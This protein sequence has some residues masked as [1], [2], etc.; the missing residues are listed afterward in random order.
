TNIDV[1]NAIL[2][3]ESKMNEPVFKKLDLEAFHHF[4]K[5][6]YIRELF[7]PAGSI[8]TSKIH[9]TE[10]FALVLSGVVTVVQ[11]DGE[12]LIEA[13]YMQ[14]TK[15]GTKRALYVHEDTVWITIH[16]TSATTVEEVEEEIIAKDF[17]EFEE[18]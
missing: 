2:N 3:L 6:V 9:K 1:R 12:R 18:S 15:P 4:A 7:M 10:H 13:P 17:S 16:P 8:V 5:G 14:I 11:E